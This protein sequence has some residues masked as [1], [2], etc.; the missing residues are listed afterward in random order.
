MAEKNYELSVRLVDDFG[1]GCVDGDFIE[2]DYLEPA[3][4]EPS[5]IRLKKSA[6]ADLLEQFKNLDMTEKNQEIA[7]PKGEE[8]FFIA[9]IYQDPALHK[10]WVDTKVAENNTDG[11]GYYRFS[12]DPRNSYKGVLEIWKKRPDNDGLPRWGRK[13]G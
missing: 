8:P 13:A 10:A 7:D 5:I 11:F 6:A 1:C 3:W 12:M 2:I 4:D 9:E